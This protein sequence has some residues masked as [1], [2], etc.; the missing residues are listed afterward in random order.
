MLLIQVALLIQNSEQKKN[1]TDKTDFDIKKIGE[2]KF[3]WFLTQLTQDTAIIIKKIFDPHQIC[4][5][6]AVKHQEYAPYVRSY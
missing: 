6:L 1:Q 2:V 3:C 4:I 5:L